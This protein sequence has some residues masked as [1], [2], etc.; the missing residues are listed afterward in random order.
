MVPVPFFRKVAS[1]FFSW[2]GK[3]CFLRA[4]TWGK[5]MVV[6]EVLDWEWFVVKAQ[7][8]VYS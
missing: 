5:K 8:N 6:V 2:T 3:K 7:L 4:L 1:S